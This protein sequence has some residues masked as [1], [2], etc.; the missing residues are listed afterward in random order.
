MVAG[1]A[2]AAVAALGG[3]SLLATIPSVVVALV[4]AAAIP[5]HTWLARAAHGRHSAPARLVAALALLAYG[6]LVAG[7]VTS[8][9]PGVGLVLAVALLWVAV[10]LPALDAM[11]RPVVGLTVLAV[12]ALLAVTA[13]AGTATTGGV[14]TAVDLE[15]IMAGLS[16]HT[17]P[18]LL[19]L[20]AAMALGS[21]LDLLS[22]SGRMRGSHT[23]FGLSATLGGSALLLVGLAGLAAAGGLEV[24][25]N[26]LGGAGIAVAVTGLVA[27]R[28]GR[29]ARIGAE[30]SGLG[31]LTFHGAVVLFLVGAAT[32]HHAGGLLALFVAPFITLLGV[33]IATVAGLCF[34]GFVLADHGERRPLHLRARSREWLRRALTLPVAVRRMR[35]RWRGQNG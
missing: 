16:T 10:C 8:V 12:P 7:V 23:L 18:V 31:A 11:P 34:A 26:R 25:F 14:A 17:G 30:T 28:A 29:K 19:V 6:V 22:C 5:R 20:G 9:V 24:G 2:A 1:S 33:S 3:G 21:L 32:V 27:I 35:P 15:P 4:V 13:L